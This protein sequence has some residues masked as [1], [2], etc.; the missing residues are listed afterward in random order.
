[1][2]SYFVW[3]YESDR[4]NFLI[5]ELLRLF[6]LKSIYFCLLSGV[7]T[8]TEIEDDIP[9]GERKTVTDFCYLLDKSKQLFNGL[10]S[11]CIYL[12]SPMC[13]FVMCLY[14]WQE[15]YVYA[16]AHFFVVVF[17]QDY[18]KSVKPILTKH[19]IRGISIAH[20]RTHSNLVSIWFQGWIQE[21][22]EWLLN[23]GWFFH[24]FVNSFKSNAPTWMKK[25]QIYLYHNR[26][27]I[28]AIW[29]LSRNIKIQSLMTNKVLKCYYNYSHFCS[30]LLYAGFTCSRKKKTSAICC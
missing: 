12:L 4:Y 13:C 5:C 9:L 21:F 20:W 3:K 7:M 16:C 14:L 22:E 17:W 8:G 24:I 29:R 6:T 27:S 11:V 23:F 10:R 18:S 19:F 30:S 2:C 15:D 25:Y 28:G 1:M 26:L